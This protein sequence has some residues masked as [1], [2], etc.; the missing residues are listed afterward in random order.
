MKAAE[1]AFHKLKGFWKFVTGRR[2]KGRATNAGTLVDEAIKGDNA[3]LQLLVDL[4]PSFAA[5]ILD[6][7]KRLFKKYPG[8]TDEMQTVITSL[9]KK[10]VNKMKK[11]MAKKLK[12]V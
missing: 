4:K 1:S 7:F 8:S 12:S 6:K 11:E 9:D 2:G 10:Q 3:A 5:S